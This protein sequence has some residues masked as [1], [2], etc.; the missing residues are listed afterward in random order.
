MPNEH[1]LAEEDLADMDDIPNWV[2]THSVTCP[3]CG[4]L[5]DERETISLWND[6]RLPDGEAHKSCYDEWQ[7]KPTYIVLDLERLYKPPSV[8]EPVG[9][10]VRVEVK[11]VHLNRADADNAASGAGHF[12]VKEVTDDDIPPFGIE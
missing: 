12:V 2:D 7:D 8:D 1:R 3:L 5:A 9:G 6:P 4:D 10:H 11:S